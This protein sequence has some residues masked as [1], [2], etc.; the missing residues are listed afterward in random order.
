MEIGVIG[1]ESTHIRLYADA[2]SALYPSG[3]IRITR[4]WCG[5]N[6][7]SETA[8]ERI[9]DADDLINKSDAVIIA[10]RNGMHHKNHA[11]RCLRA[12]KPVF[13]DKPFA[14][15]PIDAVEI[16]EEA[17]KTGTLIMG[18]S[19]LCYVPQISELR[20]EAQQCKTA[21]IWYWSDLFSPYGGWPFYGSH[22]CDLCTAIFGNNYIDVDAIQ[23]GGTIEAHVAYPNFT[24]TLSTIAKPRL[25]VVEIG[26][27]TAQLSEKECFFYAMKKFTQSQSKYNYTDKR[28]T[29]S[30]SLMDKIFNCINAIE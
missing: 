6:P 14:L 29:A 2:L 24:V 7:Y 22:T 13:V 25:P 26:G 19:A 8:L 21:S 16:Y 20:K 30:V 15:L 27:K 18:G 10:L 23:N 12:G 9:L 11:V 1:I 28:L 17:E 4:A 5:D 3:E